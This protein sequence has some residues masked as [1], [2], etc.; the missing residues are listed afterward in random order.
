MRTGKYKFLNKYKTFRKKK[1][2]KACKSR[3]EKV[4]FLEANPTIRWQIN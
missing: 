3:K 4:S 1:R 2:N